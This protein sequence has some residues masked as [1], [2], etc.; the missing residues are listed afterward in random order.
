MES[1]KPLLTRDELQARW[2]LSRSTIIRLEKLRQL[3]PIKLHRAV[4]YL[5]ADIVAIETAPLVHEE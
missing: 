3:R 2:K 5:L 4:R 1:P